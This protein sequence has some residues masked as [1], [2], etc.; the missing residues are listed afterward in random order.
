MCNRIC[1]WR[2][3]AGGWVG[4]VVCHKY[5]SAMRECKEESLESVFTVNMIGPRR[6]KEGI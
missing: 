1:V 4:D 2:A 5:E 3:P 6:V